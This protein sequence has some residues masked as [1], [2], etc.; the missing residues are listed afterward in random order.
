MNQ[1]KFAAAQMMDHVPWRRFQTCV[2]RYRTYRTQ[3]HARVNQPFSA[4]A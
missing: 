3:F 1:G 2:D 4:A